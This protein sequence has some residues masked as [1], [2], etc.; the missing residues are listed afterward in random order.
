MEL[1]RTLGLWDAT[2]VGLG[3]IIGAGI[4]V[5][6]GPAAAKAGD[7]ILLALILAAIPAT[8][9]ALA[10]AALGATYPKAGGTYYFGRQLL[11][12][13][14]G[15]GAGWTFLLAK[16]ASG[17][18][19]AKGFGYYLTGGKGTPAL[20]AAL[21]LV[22]VVTLIDLRGPKISATVNALLVFLKIGILLLFAALAF[23]QSP[24]S[25]VALTPHIYEPTKIWQGAALLFSVYAGYAR[26]ATLAEEVKEPRQTL[27]RAVFFALGGSLLVYLLVVA[28]ALRLIGAGGIAV[29]LAPLA[30]ALRQ[31]G[32]SDFA[33]IIAAGAVIASA[34]VFLTLYRGNLPRFPC[35]VPRGRSAASAWSC[36]RGRRSD[37]RGRVFRRRCRRAVLYPRPAHP[38]RH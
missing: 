37:R 8:L 13:I 22:M 14:A 25:S 31:R 5:G 28:G 35:H 19:M 10:S 4:F 20:L 17:A 32:L 12:P 18:V 26:I 24:I 23:T 29:S 27:P 3:A 30:D 9:N 34:S 7:G 38:D 1:R 36:Q 15:F 33:P 16:C 11:G 2:L 21:A 6:I